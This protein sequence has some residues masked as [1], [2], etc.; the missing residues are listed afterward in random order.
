MTG[1][2]VFGAFATGQLKQPRFCVSVVQLVR[3]PLGPSQYQMEIETAVV[4]KNS[5]RRSLHVVYVYPPR[6]G[7]HSWTRG[8][9]L[10]AGSVAR[11]ILG[12]S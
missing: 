9:V 5:N 8:A 1:G 10:I 7:S 6:M 12:R 2:L 11:W 4:N 3:A